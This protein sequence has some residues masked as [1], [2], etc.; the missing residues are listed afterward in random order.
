MRRPKIFLAV[1]ATIALLAASAFAAGP[2]L[3]VTPSHVHQ[4]GKVTFTGS[5]WPDNSKV[6]LLLGR[7][8]TAANKFATVATNGRGK[9]SYTLP[10]KP[11]APTG[12]YVIQACRKSCANKV[13]R[14]MTIL[15]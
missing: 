13:S 4:G 10:I 9:F 12:R 5:G 7:P 6:S 1:T 11:T 8:N 2:S 3:T 14:N 15:P